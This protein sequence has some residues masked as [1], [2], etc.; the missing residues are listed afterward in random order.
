MF[1]TLPGAEVERAGPGTRDR[2]E[3]G[4]KGEERTHISLQACL[5]FCLGPLK[6]RSTE[7]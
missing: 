2:E 5:G 4:R 6:V 1:L 7:P 3:V